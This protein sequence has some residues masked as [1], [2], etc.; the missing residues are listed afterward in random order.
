MS[1]P[2]NQ[3]AA[4]PPERPRELTELLEKAAKQPG[5]SELMSVYESWKHFEEA[6]RPHRELLAMKRIVMASNTSG[7]PVRPLS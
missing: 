4:M 7:P 5:V 1:K 3:P 2:T 6:A